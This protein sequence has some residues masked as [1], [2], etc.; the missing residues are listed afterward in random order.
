MTDTLSGYDD[1]PDREAAFAL[2]TTRRDAELAALRAV[3][4]DLPPPDRER[5]KSA[6]RALHE[7]G[8]ELASVTGGAVTARDLTT[9]AETARHLAG[10]PH[11]P[12]PAPGRGAVAGLF[13]DALVAP[14]EYLCAVL[15]WERD[16]VY[17]PVLMSAAHPRWPDPTERLIALSLLREAGVPTDEPAED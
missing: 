4:E 5:L 15:C 1:G 11:P 2:Y 10:L 12:G 14:A 13:A 9:N 6:L 7:A 3:W 17:I 16:E 8:K